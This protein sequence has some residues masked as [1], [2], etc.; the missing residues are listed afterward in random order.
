MGAG[1]IAILC[2][3]SATACGRI[4]Y[5]EVSR[6]P[7][8]ATPDA[9]AACPEGMTEISPGAPVCIELTE[10]GTETWLVAKAQCEALQRRLCADLEWFEA[11]VDATG[12][13][14]MI[15]GG[16]EWV[17]EELDGI[18]QK[19]GETAC[20]VMST[21]VVTDPYEYRCCADR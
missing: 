17:A 21:H 18:A 3:V 13:V 4:G 12:L 10:R 19:R 9:L 2:M 1:W 14:D 16:Y 11:C 15:D 8:D 7:P 20:T 6:A 5:D